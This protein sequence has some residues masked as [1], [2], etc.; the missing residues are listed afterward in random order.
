MSKD[1]N[2]NY[3]LKTIKLDYKIFFDGIATGL[4]VINC[5]KKCIVVSPINNFG[6]H[7][8]L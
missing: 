4:C 1:F 2:R 8:N 6:H 7:A 5:S 3:T